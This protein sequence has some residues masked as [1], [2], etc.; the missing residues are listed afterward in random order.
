VLVTYCSIVAPSDYSIEMPS[1]FTV[2]KDASSR[3]SILTDS[4][5]LIVDYLGPYLQP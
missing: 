4:T 3:C 5:I 2:C 1:Y